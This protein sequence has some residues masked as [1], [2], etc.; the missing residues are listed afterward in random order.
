MWYNPA[1]SDLDTQPYFDRETVSVKI[2]LK[3][4]YRQEEVHDSG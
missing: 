4:L 2:Y 1:S 3:A